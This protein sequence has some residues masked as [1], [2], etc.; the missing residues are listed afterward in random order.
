M[1]IRPTFKDVLKARKR[2]APYLVRTPLRH[3][4]GLSEMLGFEAYVKH[5]NHQLT[6][7]FKVRGGIN[8]VSQL[9]PEERRTGVITASTG[10]H[11]QSVAYAA[12]LF[13]VRAVIC[14][15]EKANPDKVE[16]IRSFGAEIIDE[17][18]DFDDARLNAEGL[19]EEHGYRYI[20][21]GDEPHLIAGVGTIGLE[22]MEDLPDVDVVIVPVGGGSGAAGIS[23]VMR[24]AAPRVEVI[25][26]Q[27]ERAPSVYLSWKKGEIVPTE[28]A[29]TMADGLANRRAFELPLEIMRDQ[30]DDF[31]LVSEDE[32][33]EAIRLYV[34]KAHTIAEGAGAASLAAAYKIRDRLQGK[35]VVLE[36][37][38]GNLTAQ[39]LRGILCR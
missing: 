29:D 38:G 36:L 25:A 15:P 35:R 18:R 30:I 26:V 22:I 6:G 33:M 8:L 31:I 34:E 23:T 4:V 24:A 39:M 37:S 12:H 1:W 17:G 5:E 21:S 20:H 3:Y 11:G 2:I 32:M 9:S 28:S 14:V 10:N 7:A 13:G 27:A 16:A 19:A